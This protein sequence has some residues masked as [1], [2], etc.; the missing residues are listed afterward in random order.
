MAWVLSKE[1]RADRLQDHYR[2]G[3]VNAHRL[4]LVAY[5]TL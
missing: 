2:L 3:Q 4:Y 1:H 5:W